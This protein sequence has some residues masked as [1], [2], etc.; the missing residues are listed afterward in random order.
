MSGPDLFSLYHHASA[1]EA[2]SGNS[3]DLSASGID[4]LILEVNLSAVTGSIQFIVESKDPDGNYEP[5]YT[6]SVLSAVTPLIVPI[7]AGLQVNQSFSDT[8]RVRWVIV[9]GPATFTATVHGRKLE[10][11]AGAA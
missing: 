2:A 10:A 5:I 8:V 11:A 9:T 7:G 6:G 1:A 4:I 3:G